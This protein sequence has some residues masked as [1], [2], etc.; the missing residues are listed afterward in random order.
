MINTKLT[1]DSL[2]NMSL[3]T[4]KREYI[5][6]IYDAEHHPY[7]ETCEIY[8]GPNWKLVLHCQAFLRTSAGTKLIGSDY[9]TYRNVN[10]GSSPF[11]RIA[12]CLYGMS[13][14]DMNTCSRS[15]TSTLPTTYQEDVKF[16]SVGLDEIA[17]ELN[18]L[19][20]ASRSS[21][22]YYQTAISRLK[23][24]LATKQFTVTMNTAGQFERKYNAVH[25][26]LRSLEESMKFRKMLDNWTNFSERQYD[27]TKS[28]D[29]VPRG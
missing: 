29:T 6:N 8:P 3:G 20:A 23:T 27:K 21:V 15:L 22:Q 28:S 12:L 19:D 17:N 26:R 10:T 13:Q 11:G 2:T 7:R 24:Q 4:S 9:N 25:S 5:F 14:Y 18:D 16:S 1:D